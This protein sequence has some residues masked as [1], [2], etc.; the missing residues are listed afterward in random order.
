MEA[1]ALQPAE[2]GDLSEFIALSLLVHC[3]EPLA[4]RLVVRGSSSG[5]CGLH[6]RPRM[7]VRRMRAVRRD[8]AIG[9]RDAPSP[10]KKKGGRSLPD[11]LRGNRKVGIREPPSHGG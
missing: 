5:G 8:P 11:H 2:A 1:L 10:S 7:R 9:P 6:G 4:L 3:A